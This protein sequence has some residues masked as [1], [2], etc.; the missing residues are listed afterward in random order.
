MGDQM[1]MRDKELLFG[2]TLGQN[3]ASNHDKLKE[4]RAQKQERE[5]GLS[6]YEG[7]VP[8]QQRL[9][10]LCSDF[11]ESVWDFKITDLINFQ[12][13]LQSIDNKSERQPEKVKLLNRLVKE[14]YKKYQLEVVRPDV[15][16]IVNQ[17]KTAFEKY[18][19]QRKQAPQKDG[20]I[21]FKHAEY[22]QRAGQKQSGK[23]R[24]KGK[25]APK[26]Q[27]YSGQFDI[28]AR[29]AILAKQRESAKIDVTGK[30]DNVILNAV[31]APDEEP[32]EQSVILAETLNRR[33]S[34]IITA[35]QM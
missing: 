27:D 21:N 28:G 10:L 7:R 26:N 24:I 14:L 8:L 33:A 15:S 9:I 29:R 16:Y 12:N 17:Y 19:E 3:F 32:A 1:L 6:I 34:Q 20:F 25:S 4:T 35:P 11:L 5:Q 2:L 22:N 30:D 13:D 23:Q 31:F 18:Y